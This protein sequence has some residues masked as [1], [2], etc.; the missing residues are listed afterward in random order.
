[1]SGQEKERKKPNKQNHKWKRRNHNETVEIKKKKK[2]ILW[3]TV[4]QQIW[5][6]RRNGQ[7]PETYSL[8]KQYEKEID[9]LNRSITSN[10]IE[11]V[12]KTLPTNR[13]PGPYIFIGKFNQT[14]K[15]E[16][17]LFLLKLFQK[18]E[19]GILPQTFCD[20][21]IILTS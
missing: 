10:E 21:T 3:T 6:P 16:L 19:E 7:L 12:I 17:I 9:Q 20:A 15:E 11:Y 14:Y 18:V 13:S 2:R 1:M 8:P 5:Q 4:Y